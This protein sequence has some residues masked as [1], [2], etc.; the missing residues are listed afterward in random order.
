MLKRFLKA[1]WS[2]FYKFEM[3]K[4]H[5]QLI[6]FFLKGR[7]TMSNIAILTAA[8]VGSRFGQDEIGRAS[9]RERVYRSV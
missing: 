6:N 5:Q 9:C 8:G 1:K 4:F 3:V 7:P 2:N